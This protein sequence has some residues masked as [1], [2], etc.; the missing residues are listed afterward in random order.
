MENLA[1]DLTLDQI[2]DGLYRQIAELI[3]VENLVRLAELAGGTTVYLPKPE[4]L[5]KPVRDARIKQEFNGYNHYELARKYGVTERWVR[6]LCGDGV[7]EGQVSIVDF[8]GTG[9]NDGSG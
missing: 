7:V 1:K 9:G 2:P 6:A 3:G 5:V 8:M 4:S